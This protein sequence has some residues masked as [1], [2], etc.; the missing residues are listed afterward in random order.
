MRQEMRQ[1]NLGG[2][3]EERALIAGLVSLDARQTRG[4]LSS[5]RS[6]EVELK[7]ATAA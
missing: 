5:Q 2:Y 4:F 3:P 1:R 6:A 7:G